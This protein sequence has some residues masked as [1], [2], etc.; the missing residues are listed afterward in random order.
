MLQGY[1]RRHFI[2]IIN[3]YCQYTLPL[4]GFLGRIERILKSLQGEKVLITMD[5][6]V[7]YELWFDKATHS[8]RILLEEFIGEQNLPILNKPDNPPT[9]MGGSME[10][11]IDITLATNN[12]LRHVNEWRVDGSR[13]TSDHN[14]IITEMEGNNIS[15]RNWIADLG[16]NTKKADWQKFGRLVE[17]N[18]LALLLLRKQ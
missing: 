12:L 18:R 9:S 11:N 1:G 6:K 13:T 4:E 10:S 16:Y 15:C 3:V 5:S 2:V 14:L 8:K 17:Q 7:K